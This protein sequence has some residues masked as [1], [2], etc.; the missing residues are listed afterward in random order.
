MSNS[1]L[2]LPEVVVTLEEK[3]KSLLD[4]VL[5]F[6]ADVQS[7]KAFHPLR[8]QEI[9]DF[10]EAKERA[11]EEREGLMIRAR[12]VG[13]PE[14]VADSEFEEEHPRRPCGACGKFH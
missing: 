5:E 2:K 4:E 6:T 8:L 1:P 9:R 11:Q 14:V 7:G 3:P 12:S 10:R 13:I